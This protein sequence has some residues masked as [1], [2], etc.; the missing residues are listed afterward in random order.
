[1]KAT[2]APE[3]DVAVVGGS[4][5]GVAAAL[6]ALEAGCKVVLSEAS[7][8]L[9]GQMTAQGVSALDEH[10]Y[11]ETFANRRYLEL[12]ER[13]R[14]HYQERYDLPTP[15]NGETPLNPGNGW[16]SRLCFEP[17]V[18]ERALREMLASFAASGRLTLLER[19]RPRRAL[20]Q[21][22]RVLE[23][24]LLG[25]G[26][27]EVAVRAAYFLDA[28]DLGELLPLTETAYVTGA[29]SQEDT[30]E[31]H[32]VPGPARPRE[33][34]S[35]TYSFAV[36]YRPGENHTIPKP[37]GYARF[38]D[39]QPYSLL[40]EPGSP[41]EA[42]FRM[43]E[44]GPKGELPFWTYRRIR[45]SSLLCEERQPN[46]LAL[47]NW[48][49]NDYRFGNLIDR[50]APAAGRSLKEAK[51]L[52]LGFLYWLQT[53]CP[54]DEGGFGYPELKLRQDVMGTSDGL[55]QAPYIRE[56]RRI[57]ALARV[58]E[59]DI[60]PG[61]G[62]GARAKPRPDSVGVGWYAI[63][64]HPCVGNEETSL[65]LPTLPFQL[66]L[67]ALIPEETQNLLAACKN[68]GVTHVTNGAYRLHPVE[69][70]VGEAAGTL[71]AFCL[72]EGR[73]PRQVWASKALTHRL[74]DQLLGQGVPLAWATDAPP[75]HP[76][77]ARAQRLVLSGV[78]PDLGKRHEG[79][80]LGLGEPLEPPEA[81]ALERAFGK[82]ATAASLDAWLADSSALDRVS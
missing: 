60:T 39:I 73:S 2:E 12:R 45:D 18:G 24:A 38:R 37:E 67:G 17:R 54:R 28:T 33:V 30:G 22:G 13:I 4:L 81:R 10:P 8:W 50:P 34:Q 46:D 1:M 48:A 82:T 31:A 57:R 20:C 65:Y 78:L 64:L 47:I 23:V 19:H 16:V 77:F 42:N 55:S 58:L 5:G 52:S 35:F 51:R 9:G 63:D 53:E 14:Q 21:G 27:R 43:F 62:K 80:E 25:P 72:Q 66:P 29:E 36:E 32:A 3:C 6:A 56:S 15:P 11:I 79:L 71:A 61:P 41:K 59:E 49:G 70:A 44:R 69:W 68:I 7:R 75:G 76:R 40:L 26:R 74:Q